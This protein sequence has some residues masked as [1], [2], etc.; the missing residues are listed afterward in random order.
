MPPLTAAR[1]GSECVVR[2]GA[3]GARAALGPGRA[4]I[5]PGQRAAAPAGHDARAREEKA[6]RS[7][8]SQRGDVGVQVPVAPAA[9]AAAPLSAADAGG[10]A[11]AAAPPQSCLLCGR[12][13]V[14]SMADLN[15]EDKRQIA[16]VLKQVLELSELNDRSASQL[17]GEKQAREEAE[18]RAAALADEVGGLRGKL[19]QALDLLRAYQ[20]RVREMQQALVTSDQ[21]LSALQHEH[22]TLLARMPGARAPPPTPPRAAPAVAAP[23]AGDLSIAIDSIAAA[24]AQSTDPL[25]TP[26]K[27]AAALAADSAAPHEPGTQES[28]PA[29][30]RPAPT[31]HSLDEASSALSVQATLGS[32][33]EPPLAEH[34]PPVHG[35]AL[36]GHGRVSAASQA[37]GDKQTAHHGPPDGHIESRHADAACSRQPV[38]SHSS[39]SSHSPAPS[40][41]GSAGGPQEVL[42]AQGNRVVQGNGAGNGAVA[43]QSPGAVAASTCAA[44]G[45]SK[46]RSSEQ[47]L[48][49]ELQP[50]S[51]TVAAENAAACGAMHGEGVHSA[52]ACAA[53][54]R[55]SEEETAGMVHAE[56]SECGER[57][58]REVC[59]EASAT[60]KRCLMFEQTAVGGMEVARSQTSSRAVH[61]RDDISSSSEEEEQAHIRAPTVRCVD[62]RFVSFAPHEHPSQTLDCP[63]AASVHHAA[64]APLPTPHGGAAA[65]ANEHRAS[66][67]VVGLAGAAW[68]RLGEC[69]EIDE[70]GQ[71]CG[72][73]AANTAGN[74]TGQV[75]D[76]AEQE[77][78][79]LS[80]LVEKALSSSAEKKGSSPSR[81]HKSVSPTKSHS[82]PLALDAARLS[83]VKVRQ[84][85]DAVPSAAETARA[86]ATASPAR[87]SCARGGGGVGEA[88]SSG[89]G[90]R[91]TQRGRGAAG[92]KRGRTLTRV[93]AAQVQNGT[94]TCS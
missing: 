80:M 22:K 78:E 48:A 32:Q 67:S 5:A 43:P 30:Q 86:H 27:T 49:E 13:A 46:L 35:A 42:V 74:T 21:A 25:R 85:P 69:D 11:A 65:D 91:G 54:V 31:P 64:A 17:E 14:C 9:P 51:A 39:H 73:S 26:S 37:H 45:A 2:P 12:G 89:T 24:L 36:S 50:T 28:T 34:G 79:L 1:V 20:K 56:R 4:L 90:V 83:A 61:V 93:R 75:A 76:L 57:G 53:D 81:T 8:R 58:S 41:P 68:D 6:R 52:G 23:G 59:K 33:G 7:Q 60:R 88:C 38:S 29:P 77:L 71:T 63:P 16:A 40:T 72:A 62:N 47:G 15:E 19:A 84:N 10:P 92:A 87:S 94:G 18:A 82:K 3:S 44:S 66:A 55:R 70:E